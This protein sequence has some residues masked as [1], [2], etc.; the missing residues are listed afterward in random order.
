MRVQSQPIV[1]ITAFNIDRYTT[2]EA[3]LREYDEIGLRTIELNG[4]VRQHVI[5]ALQPYIERGEVWISSLHNYCPRPDIL[6]EIDLRL[7]SPDEPLRRLAVQH[8]RHTIDTASRLGARAVVLHAGEILPLRPLVTVLKDLYRAEQQD[9]VEYVRGRDELVAL[10]R[11]EG[12]LYVRAAE[13]SITELAEYVA[14]AGLDVRLGLETR[15]YYNQI[16]Q[17]VEFDAWFERLDSAPVDL[18]YDLGHGEIVENM[19]LGSK[20]ALFERHGVRLGGLHLHDCLGIRDHLVPGEGAIDFAFL[21]P[22][23]RSDVLRVLEYG[24][25]VQPVARIKDG[26]AYLAAAGMW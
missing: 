6:D 8:T 14:R 5:D 13:R 16:P 10:R 4:R 22:H 7:S 25:K 12:P 21:L 18:W 15:D 17:L 19:G 20:A 2:V 3:F 24:S 26:I 1:G 9:S 11:R 23:L